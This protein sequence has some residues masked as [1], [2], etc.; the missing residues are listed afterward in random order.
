[1]ISV[2]ETDYTLKPAL[3]RSQ[4]LIKR[5]FDLLVSVTGLIFLSWLIFLAFIIASLDTR[6]N[7]IFAQVRIGRYGKP[8]KVI[9]VRTMRDMSDVTTNVTTKDDPR[10]TPVGKLLRRSKVDE[11]PQLINVLL[12]QMSL[13]GPRPDV[14]G[15]VDKLE[16]ADRIILSIRPGITSPATLKYRNEEEILAQQSN[17]EQ[18]NREVIYPDKVR[19]NKEYIANYSFW[20][21]LNVIWQTVAG[22]RQ[23]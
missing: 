21:D 15:F 8:F 22:K 5:A 9:K 18:Y 17:P 3:S 4:R 1:M 2:K 23:E 6:R 11:L 13:V 14:P 12:G 16:G 10:I 19:M 7:G 20:Q